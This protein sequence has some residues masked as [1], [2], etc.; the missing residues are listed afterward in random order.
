MSEK[1]PQR[2][3]GDHRGLE[4]HNIAVLQLSGALESLIH[5]HICCLSWSSQH[6]DEIDGAG[7][8]IL[9]DTK[10]LTGECS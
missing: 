3:V 7:L 4:S 9:L 8:L 5:F 1:A 6:L 2:W 10:E